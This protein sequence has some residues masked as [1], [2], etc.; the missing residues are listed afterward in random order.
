MCINRESSS[1]LA[2]LP[3]SSNYTLF[4]RLFFLGSAADHRA[5]TPTTTP[6]H[7]LASPS[8]IFVQLV[9]LSCLN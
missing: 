1:P 8:L 5:P 6:F 7:Y 9:A 3:S 2:S 4:F